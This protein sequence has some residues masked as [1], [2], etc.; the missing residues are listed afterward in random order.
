MPKKDEGFSILENEETK[1]PLKPS[2]LKKSEKFVIY[3]IVKNTLFL[4]S[5]KEERRVSAILYPNKKVGDF[6][7]L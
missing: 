5:E 6:I 1:T 7:E 2:S 4:K 3:Q